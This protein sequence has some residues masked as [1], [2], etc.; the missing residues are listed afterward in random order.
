MKTTAALSLLVGT[1]SA[2]LDTPINWPARFSCTKQTLKNGANSTN[3]WNMD[4]ANGVF[5]LTDDDPT[6]PYVTEYSF[7]HNNT[8]Y[9]IDNAN[10]CTMPTTPSV[11]PSVAVPSSAVWNATQTIDGTLCDVYVDWKPKQQS[12]YSVSQSS[13]FLVHHEQFD[14]TGQYTVNQI[15]NYNLAPTTIVLPATCTDKFP[16]FLAGAAAKAAPPGLTCD[17]GCCGKWDLVCCPNSRCPGSP[18]TGPKGAC[19]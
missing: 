6:T 13:G 3:Q 12:K 5:E 10:V 7:L 16:A 15:S 4:F 18:T 11:P 2:H 8:E 19:C 9:Y 17:N 1:A 14:H